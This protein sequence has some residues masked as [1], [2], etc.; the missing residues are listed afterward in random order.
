MQ[1]YAHAMDK[2]AKIPRPPRAGR[3]PEPARLAPTADRQGR[4]EGL[5]HPIEVRDKHPRDSG[6]RRTHQPA[7]RSAQGF[8]GHPHEP[9][10]RGAQRARAAGPRRESARP[11]CT[12]CRKAARPGRPHRG[13]VPLLHGEGSARH[14]GQGPG[15]LPGKFDAAAYGKDV[16]FTVTVT[17]PVT[18][19]CP[20]SKAISAY[21]AH[22]QRGYV[23]LAL[24]S[25]TPIWIEDMIAMVEE[26]A[27][28]EIYPCSSGRRKI[29]HRAG[30]RQSR[31][32]RGPRPQRGP[33]LQP[34]SATSPGIRSR[35]KT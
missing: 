25:V 30:L 11:C 8:Q 20:C 35:R 7:R 18:T 15:R 6:H 1:L 21:G 5:L 27:S 22:N 2:S 16:T 29:R 19:L 10:R 34:A 3:F 31:F 23:T 26:S 24:R 4:R 12:S 13:G 28:S 33:A 32:R 17:I 14:E 9:F